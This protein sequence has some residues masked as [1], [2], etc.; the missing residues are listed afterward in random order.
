MR[1]SVAVRYKDQHDYVIQFRAAVSDAESQGFLLPE[2]AAI[3]V[4][5]IAAAPI[6]VLAPSTATSRR[7][8]MP[9]RLHNRTPRGRAH[10][11]GASAVG[12][13]RV[14]CGELTQH[15]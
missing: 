13:R 11:W 1:P 5:L 9:K 14:G 8:R 10:C 4:H 7:Y 12:P 3:V 6:F 2:N 15:R